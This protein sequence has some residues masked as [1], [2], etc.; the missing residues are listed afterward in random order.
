MIKARRAAEQKARE[1]KVTEK[2]N[3]K[4]EREARRKAEG[5]A[6]LREQI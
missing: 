1:D 3:R 6:R 2:Q 4:N 5:I